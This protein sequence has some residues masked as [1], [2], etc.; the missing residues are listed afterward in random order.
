MDRALLEVEDLEVRFGP[1]RCVEGLSFQLERGG[2]L[3]VVG[4]SGSGK[5]LAA[6][7]LLGLLAGAEVRGRVWFQGR[8]LLAMDGAGLRRIRGRH[9]AMI[10]QDPMTSLNPAHSV[11]EQLTEG[12]RLHLGLGRGA[13]RSQAVEW[14]EQVGVP[15]PEARLRQFPHQL[16]GGLRQ[17][18]LIAM[19]LCCGADLL[20]ADEPTTALDV[21]IQAQILDLLREQQRQRGM[22]LLLISHDLAVVASSCERIQVM[23]AGRI[24]EA[25]PT[26]ALLADPRHPYSAGL[27]RSAAFGSRP[28]ERLLEIPGQVPD[29][30]DPPSGC[31]FQDRCALAGDRCRAAEPGD[32]GAGGRSWRCH[33]PLGQP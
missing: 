3:G 7:A 8:D 31:R 17:R 32:A 4:E 12:L 29:L 33:F 18:V 23:Y 25:G 28:R 15:A 5:S 9:M 27:V 10:F 2:T 1:V 21:T 14:L 11:G 20:I 6:L 16:S 22:A 13:A 19:A 24:V 26:R 30:A